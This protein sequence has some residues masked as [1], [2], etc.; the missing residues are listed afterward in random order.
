MSQ[1]KII[2]TFRTFAF[3]CLIG[4]LLVGAYDLYLSGRYFQ[5][6]S[7]QK[8]YIYNLLSVLTLLLAVSLSGFIILPNDTMVRNILIGVTSAL[9]ILGILGTSF[10]TNNIRRTNAEN[11]NFKWLIGLN[12]VTLIFSGFAIIL[13]PIVLSHIFSR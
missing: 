11:N 4:S 3:V 8:L 1:V 7:D 12:I 13:F 5:E 10:N 6:N 9:G 2:I